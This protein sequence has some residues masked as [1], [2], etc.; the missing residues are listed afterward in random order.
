LHGNGLLPFGLW[1]SLPRARSVHLTHSGRGALFQYFEALR[2]SGQLAADR[3]VVLV[4]SFHCPTVVDPVL[5]AGYDVRFYAIDEAMR[6]DQA[7]LLRKLDQREVL[8][9]LR[10]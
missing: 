1:R 9:V 5:H 7:D 8:R 4:P 3:T 2:R 6:I 10:A